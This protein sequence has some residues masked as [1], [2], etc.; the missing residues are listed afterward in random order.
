MAN[1]PGPSGLGGGMSMSVGAGVGASLAPG[2]ASSTTSQ[3]YNESLVS[4]EDLV[5]IMLLC[6]R[7]RKKK[8]SLMKFASGIGVD[9]AKLGNTPAK[10]ERENNLKEYKT[11]NDLDTM[12]KFGAGSEFGR[13]QKE[14]ARR[15]KYGII[16]KKYNPEEQPWH[17]K[18]G[19]GK[20]AKKYRGVREGTITENTS[21]YIFTQC[22]DG[23]FEAFPVE[24]WYNFTPMIRYKY[25][26]SD[27][28][29]EEFSRRD[30]TLN[31]FNIML[32]KRVKNEDRD[33]ELDE[34]EK[35]AKSK[36]SKSKKK[37][38]DF[39]TG[40]EIITLQML[41]DMDDWANISDDDE[42]GEDDE[43][44]DEKSKEDREKEKKKGKGNVKTQKKVKNAK[45][46]S[47]DE[48]IEESDE[49]DFDDRE[50]DYISDSSSSSLS[51]PE[52]KEKKYEEK[53]VA[54]E[55]GLR[56]ILNSDEEEEEEEDVKEEE[57]VEE[58]EKKDDEKPPKEKRGSESS[59]SSS[60]SDSDID[61]DDKFTSALLMQERMERKKLGEKGDCKGAASSFGIDGT[62]SKSM[63][64]KADGDNPP[65]KKSKKDHSTPPVS[66]SNDGITEETIRRY[67]Q[68]K[69]MTTKDLL[70]KFRS[71]KLNMTFEQMS[72]MIAQLL[73]RINP[74][75]T[76]INKKL[77]LSLKKPE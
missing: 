55:S 63:K 44:D 8:L 6:A 25:L 12:P 5:H 43:D 24:E 11:A 45:Q 48:A 30:K 57:E 26:N 3:E 29:E 33:T 76:T 64:R 56:N 47:D 75:R 31:Y 1:K 23:A 14:E 65:A 16:L 10:L 54:D 61:K 68:R 42:D 13:D 59:S 41:T 50:V 60:D 72:N 49:G 21:Y 15:K 39:V 51:E 69:P 67:L 27:E 7:D 73:K 17:L 71:K 36:A 18:V 70:Q 19:S 66:S 37:N 9:F 52:E 58:E 28:A 20:Q 46:N 35:T 32:K 62:D 34:E 4:H 38:K 2:A 40:I 77:Y 53:G 74:E 22:A